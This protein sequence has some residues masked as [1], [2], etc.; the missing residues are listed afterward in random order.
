MRM[1]LEY[2][3]INNLPALW[4]KMFTNLIKNYINSIDSDLKEYCSFDKMV[5]DDPNE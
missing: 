2:I 4:L 5:S 1:L 3:T